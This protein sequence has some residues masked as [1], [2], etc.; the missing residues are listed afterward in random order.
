LHHY[1]KDWTDWNPDDPP[2]NAMLTKSF[3]NYR[4]YQEEESNIDY[5]WDDGNP[6]SGWFGGWEWCC[7]DATPLPETH[8]TSITDGQ[9]P[10]GPRIFFHS[11]RYG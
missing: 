3:H 10:W 9:R 6:D 5:S 2:N 11:I 4:N 1:D 8:W 7:D